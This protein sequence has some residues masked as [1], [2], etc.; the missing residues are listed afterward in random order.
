MFWKS[1]R[2]QLLVGHYNDY[3]Y[4]I[5]VE[6]NDVGFIYRPEGND[7]RLKNFVPFPFESSISL[8]RTV[9]GGFPVW[10]LVTLGFPCVSLRRTVY[11]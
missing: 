1:V 8:I 11:H 6:V 2:K 5:E 10:L 4:R 9:T 3:E 7:L